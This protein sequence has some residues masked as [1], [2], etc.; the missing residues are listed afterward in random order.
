[1][2][3]EYYDPNNVWKICDRCGFKYR[4]SEMRREWTGLQVCEQCWE[5]KHPQLSVRAIP[6][7]I[8]VKNARP[9]QTDKFDY[10][11]STIS[12]SALAAKGATSIVVSDTTG[13]VADYPIAV[14]LDNGS[15]I[16]TTVDK[17]SPTQ[18]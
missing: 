9:R 10:I 18:T 7:K 12:L 17:V 15:I 3:R 14:T 5:P 8:A 13:I 1:M 11:E 2:S 16:W 4:N 6:E